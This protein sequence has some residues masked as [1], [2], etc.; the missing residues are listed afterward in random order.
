MCMPDFDDRSILGVP[1]I[2]H[3]NS[4]WSLMVHSSVCVEGGCLCC[5]GVWEWRFCWEHLLGHR[6][7]RRHPWEDMGKGTA[8]CESWTHVFLPSVCHTVTSSHFL[9][10]FTSV[11]KWLT[12]V[13]ICSLSAGYEPSREFG[14][15][16]DWQPNKYFF[17]LAA[18]LYPLYLKGNPLHLS[19]Y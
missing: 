5:D 10:V 13:Q 18:R 12:L 16:A 2:G 14:W 8:L 3:Y 1:H 17:S 6:C 11:D 4:W 9:I 15:R 7:G 19:S